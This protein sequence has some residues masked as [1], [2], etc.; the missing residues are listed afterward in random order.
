MSRLVD[1]LVGVPGSGLSR[2]QLVV[3]GDAE[4]NVTDEPGLTA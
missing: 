1:L 2:E 4:T 3:L